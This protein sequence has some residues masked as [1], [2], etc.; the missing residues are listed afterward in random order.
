MWGLNCDPKGLVRPSKT[1]E[2]QVILWFLNNSMF[3]RL[4]LESSADKAS[5][6][7]ENRVPLC[8]YIN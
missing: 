3:K 8:I 7:F 6:V 2:E 4:L 1:I 5:A